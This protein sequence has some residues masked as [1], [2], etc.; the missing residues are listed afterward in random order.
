MLINSTVS[1]LPTVP[2]NPDPPVSLLVINIGTTYAAVTWN[3][4]PQQTNNRVV[5]FLLVLTER[6]FGLPPINITVP[7]SQLSYP[8]TNLEEFD[9]YDCAIVS[10][11]EYGFYSTA[12]SISFTTL[13]A[14]N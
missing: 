2:P 3:A 7:I 12:A 11:S 1:R 5:S 14:G 4:P 6:R 8:F 9:T 10:V 13:A